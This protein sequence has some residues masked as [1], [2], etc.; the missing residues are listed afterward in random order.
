M[1]DTYERIMELHERQHELEQILDD[2]CYKIDC[3]ED[4]ITEEA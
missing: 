1:T 3:L 4:K 2:I